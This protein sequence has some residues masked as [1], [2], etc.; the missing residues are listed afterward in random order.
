MSWAEARREA[1]RQVAE[2]CALLAE[3]GVTGAVQMRLARYPTPHDYRYFHPASKISQKYHTMVARATARAL[4]RLGHKVEIADCT[5]EGCA[6]W[7]D[8]R[9]VPT[10]SAYRSAYV[11]QLTQ[12]SK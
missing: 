12:A 4:A 7:C 6:A 2:I 1:D 11:A 3:Q 9:G 10:T 8:A 5:A